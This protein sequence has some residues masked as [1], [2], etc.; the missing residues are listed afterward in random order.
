[1]QC[2]NRASFYLPTHPDS[3][4]ASHQHINHNWEVQNKYFTPIHPTVHDFHAYSIQHLFFF[5]LVP[6]YCAGDFS[7]AANLRLAANASFGGSISLAG[8]LNV[9][10]DVSATNAHLAGLLELHLVFLPSIYL[11]H[12]TTAR[13]GPATL[14]SSLTAL[15]AYINQSLVTGGNVQALGGIMAPNMS[16]GIFLF[17]LVLF[18]LICLEFLNVTTQTN[19]GQVNISS[20]S[21]SGPFYARSG[22]NVV[23]S[24]QISVRTLLTP[25]SYH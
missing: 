6:Q 23:G 12:L 1:V 15:S 20:M 14:Y 16:V 19:L 17:S 18:N 24:S 11:F 3:H 5:P 10:Q 4:Y 22:I 7:G 2:V 8:N 9:I 13:S 25:F 21:V